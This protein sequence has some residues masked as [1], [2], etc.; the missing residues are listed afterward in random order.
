MRRALLTAGIIITASSL[1]LP[2]ATA[3]LRSSS[4]DETAGTHIIKGPR[5]ELAR[6]GLAIIRWTTNDP[7]GTDLHYAVVHYG[8]DPDDMSQISRSPTRRHGN[9]A[10]MTFRVRIQG[11]KAGTTYYYWVESFQANGISDGAKSGMNQFTMPE[12]PYVSAQP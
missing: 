3:A 10:T 4:G 12:R 9:D 1:T 2:N 5:L 11:L 8:T 6:Y 7:G